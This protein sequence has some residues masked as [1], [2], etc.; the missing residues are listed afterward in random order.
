MRLKFIP[1]QGE[2]VKTL[3]ETH[4]FNVI[5][6][7]EDERAWSVYLLEELGKCLVVKGKKGVKGSFRRYIMEIETP[8][9]VVY[10]YLSLFNDEEADILILDVEECLRWCENVEIIFCERKREVKAR[11]KPYN[12]S[13]EAKMILRMK[14]V[15]YRQLWWNR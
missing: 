12:L 9:G 15:A 13:N 5:E 2:K 8:E 1:Y 6:N 11:L 7:K 4:L 10:K 3:T 14:L